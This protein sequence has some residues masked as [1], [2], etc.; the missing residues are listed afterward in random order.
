MKKERD[1][2]RLLSLKI[3]RIMKIMLMFILVGILQM[4]HFTMSSRR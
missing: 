3:T 2:S 4:E 1:D